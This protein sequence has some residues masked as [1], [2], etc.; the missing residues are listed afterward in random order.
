MY[1]IEEI[2]KVSNIMQAQ[3]KQFD[4]LLE[5]NCKIPQATSFNDDSDSLS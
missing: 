5:D 2:L 1:L 3:V 4:A